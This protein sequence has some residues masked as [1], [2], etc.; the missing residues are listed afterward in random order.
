MKDA[1]SLFRV[2]REGRVIY[3]GR[4]TSLKRNRE[5]VGEVAPGSE[6]GIVLGGGEFDAYKKGDWIECYRIETKRQSI[7]AN[8]ESSA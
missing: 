7:S 1:K 8:A 3:E 4:C 6:C 5:E 2:L